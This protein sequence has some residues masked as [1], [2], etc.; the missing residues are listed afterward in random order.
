MPLFYSYIFYGM[1][2]YLI[3]GWSIVYITSIRV[4]SRNMGWAICAVQL[5][6]FLCHCSN[7]ICTIQKL[8]ALKIFLFK[9]AKAT[10][11]F[12]TQCLYILPI[13]ISI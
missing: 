10:L 8:F 2:H 3:Y 6:F 9:Y 1:L 12:N 13:H 5:Y 4:T 7:G 11:C